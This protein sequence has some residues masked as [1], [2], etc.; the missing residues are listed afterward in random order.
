MSRP[1][2]PACIGFVAV[3]LF[4]L[5]DMAYGGE[6]YG[7]YRADVVSVYD[8]DT[9]TADIHVFP[10]LTYRRAVRVAGID[11]PEIRGKCD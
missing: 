8:G 3:L 4:G 1:T 2:I 9:F 7:P 10:G 5:A 6:S 11:T